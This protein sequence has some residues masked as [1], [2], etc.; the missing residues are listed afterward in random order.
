M[1][2]T[3]TSGPLD[4]FDIIVKNWQRP[5][6][7][8]TGYRIYRDEGG[9]NFLITA[10]VVGLG[11]EDIKLSTK[12]SQLRLEGEKIEHEITYR[13]IYNWNI[14]QIRDSIKKVECEVKNGVAYISILTEDKEPTFQIEMK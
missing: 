10:L 8:S 13:S 2:C 3:R 5:F 9:K 7:E 12:N 1:Q 14:E 6:Q 4:L 11:K